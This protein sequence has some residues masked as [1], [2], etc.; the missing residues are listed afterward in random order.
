VNDLVHPVGVTASGV[1]MHVE[2]ATSGLRATSGARDAHFTIAV[3][4]AGGA[5]WTLLYDRAKVGDRL[6]LVR[7]GPGDFDLRIDVVG[8]KEVVEQQGHGIVGMI[9]AAATR[10]ALLVELRIELG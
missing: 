6:P 10:D 5:I 8:T 3:A 2:L 9:D 1:D 7:V 4:N